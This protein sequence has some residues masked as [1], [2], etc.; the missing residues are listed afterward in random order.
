M[1]KKIGRP[2]TQADLATQLLLESQ[3]MDSS[4]KVPLTDQPSGSSN[5]TSD[6]CSTAQNGKN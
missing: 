2:P 1:L 3:N 5:R 6:D 4:N